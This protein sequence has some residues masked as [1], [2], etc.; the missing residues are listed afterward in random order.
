MRR[1]AFV[2]LSFAL[3][4]LL[5]LLA[6]APAARAA[7]AA[8]SQARAAAPE[9]GALD[10]GDPYYPGLGNGGYDVE[11]YVLTLD[12]DLSS[13]ELV[14]STAVRARALVDLASFSLDLY[15]FDVDSVTVDGHD[16][17]FER[18]GAGTDKDGKPTPDTELLVRP[19]KALAAGATFEAVIA[20][21]GWSKGRPDDGVRFMNVGWLPTDS[22]VYVVSECVGASS[23][24]PCN[25]H[26]RDKA[27]FEFLV[28]VDE[29]YVVAANGILVDEKDLGERR[30]Y[31]WKAQDPMATYLATVN[32]AEFAVLEAKGPRGIP[33]RIYHPKDAQAEELKPFQRQPEIL[34]FL[35]SVFGPYPFEAAGGVIS[36]EQLAGALECQTMPVYSRGCNEEVIV[37]ELAHQWYGDCVSPHLWRDMWLNEGFASYSEWLWVEKNGGAE[38]YE[39]HAKENYQRLRRRKVGSPFDPGV[40]RVFSSRVYARGAM[41]LHGLRKEVGDEPFFQTL[42]TWVETHHD[43]NASTDDFVK[44]A[45]KVAGRDLKTFFDEWLYSEVTP[46]IPA[47]GPVEPEPEG[48]GR[49]RREGGGAGGSAGTGGGSAGGGGGGGGL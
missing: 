20:Y 32:V 17:H 7:Q 24:F 28:T 14:A 2:P 48:G 38:A 31:H 26:P 46:E 12:V 19:S 16:A 21:H 4:A 43:A 9:A 18:A 22:G 23:W 33:V 42:K 6:L 35:E 29:P 44:H 37:H 40:E 15:G 41:V 45:S 13:D 49:R 39:S 11:S 27:T 25:D 5:T 30:T 34:D 8:S 10:I 36:Y 47:Y 3:R 1:P